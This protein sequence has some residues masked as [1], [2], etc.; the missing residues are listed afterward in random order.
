M[1]DVQKRGQVKVMAFIFRA[2]GRKARGV[3]FIQQYKVSTTGMKRKEGT[4]DRNS[5][6]RLQGKGGIELGPGD[7]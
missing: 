6:G 5:W 3:L 4:M 7:G 1:V 2:S